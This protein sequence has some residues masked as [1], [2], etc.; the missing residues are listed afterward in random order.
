MKIEIIIFLFLIFFSLTATPTT[1]TT[2]TVAPPSD[3]QLIPTAAPHCGWSN[4][5]NRDNP[6]IMKEGKPFEGDHESIASLRKGHYLCDYYMMTKVECRAAKT[7]MSSSATGEVV[8]CDRIRGLRCKNDAQPDGKCQ[9]YEIRVFCDC[10]GIPGLHH[11]TKTPTTVATTTTTTQGPIPHVC[12]WTTWLNGHTPDNLGEMET[13][14]NLKKQYRFCDV[15]EITGIECRQHGTGKSSME[16]GQQGIVCDVAHGGLLCS[17]DKQMA[18]GGKCFDYEVRV[19]CEPKDLDCSSLN[20]TTVAPSPGEYIN[21]TP[22]PTADVF[23]NPIL[24]PTPEPQGSPTPSP[25][26]DEFGNPVRHTTFKIPTKDTT[27]RISG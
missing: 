24:H 20:V 6:T 21:P 27:T 10:Y 7:K 14:N 26:T 11:H 1:T 22:A 18:T 15:E 13:F 19:L 16:A 12:A 25:Q 23:G 8:S 17:N 3:M 5:I 2:S 4:W 9:D